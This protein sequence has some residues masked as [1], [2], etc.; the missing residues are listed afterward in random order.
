MEG[1][2][3]RYSI[4]EQFS[5]SSLQSRRAK[6]FANKVNLLFRFSDRAMLPSGVAR[7]QCRADDAHKFSPWNIVRANLVL[8]FMKTSKQYCPCCQ[9]RDGFNSSILIAESG[10]ELKQ[11]RIV[12]LLGKKIIPPIILNNTTTWA[13]NT[14]STRVFLNVIFF[15]LNW[16]KKTKATYVVRAES[17]LWRDF[18][19]W[20][21]GGPILFKSREKSTGGPFQWK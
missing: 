15:V 19:W 4:C 20:S 5:S 10:V 12:V 7:Q 14:I 16:L 21:S 13:T 11:R 1:L 3:V 2:L 17:D 9:S 18:G 6:N 8:I